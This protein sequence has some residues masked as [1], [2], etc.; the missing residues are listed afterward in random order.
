MIITLDYETEA[1]VNGSNTPPKPVGYALKLD[2]LPSE[3]VSWGHPSGNSHLWEEAHDY[4]NVAIHH[5]A[6]ESVIFHNSKFDL[7]VMKAWFGFLP[8]CPVHDTMFLAF[9]LHP[10]DRSLA[11]KTLAEKYLNMPPEEQEDLRD[12]IVANVKKATKAKWGAH[13]SKAPAA[14]VGKYAIGDTDR[15]KGLFDLFYPEILKDNDTVHA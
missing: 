6:A 14:L 7:S 11:L 5:E 8:Q 2:N 1:I 15:T 10:H 4:L 12:W 13:I 9:L 3:Y